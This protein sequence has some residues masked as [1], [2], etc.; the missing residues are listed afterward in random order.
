MPA[1]FVRRAAV[2]QEAAARPGVSLPKDE[3]ESG[4][5]VG[6]SLQRRE[7]VLVGG[8]DLHCDVVG[9]CVEVGPHRCRESLA[10]AMG[11]DPVDEVVAAAVGDVVFAEP[12]APH[13]PYVVVHPQVAVQERSGRAAARLRVRVEHHRLL[14]GHE[15]VETERRPGLGRSGR[16]R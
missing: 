9:A 12:A 11:D 7:H 4:Q 8:L 1:S 16:A 14:R 3:E 15:C 5:P 2:R 6:H 13:R 10:T